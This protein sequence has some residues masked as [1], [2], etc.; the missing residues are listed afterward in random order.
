[1]MGAERS[2]GFCWCERGTTDPGL[3][4][5]VRDLGGR[6]G[7]GIS[8]AEV[9]EVER[10]LGLRLPTSYREFLRALGW[11]EVA[12]M[13]IFGVGHD[14]PSAAVRQRHSLG[15]HRETSAYEKPRRNRE[16]TISSVC[17]R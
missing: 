17:T 3:V 4:R 11:L 12:D 2:V 7:P 9:E 15:S 14:V 13:E 10:R 1:M 16:A 8:E 5:R 6:T